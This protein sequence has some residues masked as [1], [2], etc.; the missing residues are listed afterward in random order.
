MAA[1]TGKP[2]SDVD[3]WTMATIG[4]GAAIVG[5]PFGQT[6]TGTVSW[7]AWRGVHLSLVRGTQEK[8][9]VFLKWS[10]SLL[11]RKHGKRIILGESTAGTGRE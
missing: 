10:W 2:F 3:K 5:L 1:C 6:L 7:L 4:R 8:S 11:T 9:T